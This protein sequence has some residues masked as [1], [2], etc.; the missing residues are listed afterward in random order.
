MPCRRFF[1]VRACAAVPLPAP[2]LGAGR[3]QRPP[4]P[5][6]SARRCP[7][8][9]T[10]EADPKLCD[11]AGLSALDHAVD[12]GEPSVVAALLDAGCPVD[13]TKGGKTWTP[14]M[15]CGACDPVNALL[16]PAQR[17]HD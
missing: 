17:A 7:S 9:T 10:D 5:T 16:Q 14:I 2:L 4:P 11:R 15:R 3:P 12:A 8:S 1:H 13:G 6:P